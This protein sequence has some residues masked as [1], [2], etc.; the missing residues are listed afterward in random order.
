MYFGNGHLIAGLDLVCA[1]RGPG[2][3]EGGTPL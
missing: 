2:G 3:G 1:A